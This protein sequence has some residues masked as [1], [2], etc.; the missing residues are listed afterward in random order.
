MMR[1]GSLGNV[2]HLVVMALP[3]LTCGRLD[4]NEDE[5]K[6]REL[7]TEMKRKHPPEGRYWLRRSVVQEFNVLN[8]TLCERGGCRSPCALVTAQ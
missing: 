3:Y 4:R 6:P 2:S 5:K 8:L 7:K 1:L